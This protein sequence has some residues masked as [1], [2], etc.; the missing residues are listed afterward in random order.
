MLKETAE[1]KLKLFNIFNELKDMEAG[2]DG[3][4]HDA[5]YLRYKDRPYAVHLV[6]MEDST[7][8]EKDKQKYPH[9]TEQ[10][11]KDSK[12]IKTMK[13]FIKD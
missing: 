5:I 9:Q 3:Q 13:F 4:I 1:L 10:Y 6:E 12:N 8:T 2:I 11:I 7:V